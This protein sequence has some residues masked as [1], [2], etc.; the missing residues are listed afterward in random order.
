MTSPGYHSALDYR[1]ALP[2]PFL[3]YYP[4]LWKQTLLDEKIHI[5]DRGSSLVEDVFAAGHP[6]SFQEVVARDSYDT[7]SPRFFGGPHRMVSLGDIVLARSGD[8]GPNLNIGL[9]VDSAPRWEWLRSFLSLAKMK[10]LV[11]KDWKDGFHIERVEFPKVYAVHF[12]IY[13]I[14]GRGVTSSTRLDG[15]GKGFGDYIRNKIVAIPEEII[16]GHQISHI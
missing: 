10:E 3:A 8:K 15:F 11:G 12:V 9:F 6:S 1:T 5:L 16:S 7:A 13:G 4:A 2:K 14:L